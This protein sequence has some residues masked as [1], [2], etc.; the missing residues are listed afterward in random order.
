VKSY[1]EL[2]DSQLVE[3]IRSFEDVYKLR[4]ITD[5]SGGMDFDHSWATWHLLRMLQ[6][7]LIIESGVW[8]GHSTWLIEKAC[9]GSS[10]ICFEPNQ[11]RI[12][13]K[14]ENAEYFSHDFSQHDWKNYDTNSG[15]CFFDDHQNSYIRLM[16]MKWFGFSKVIFEDNPEPGDGDF[17]SISHILAGAGAPSLQMNYAYRGGLISQARRLVKE[18]ILKRIRHNQNLLVIPNESD[19]S[20][21]MRNATKIIQMPSVQAS[22]DSKNEVKSYRNNKLV[23]LE[24]TTK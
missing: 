18:A 19:K 23:Y 5:N 6:P 24:M 3:S 7:K 10:I 22:W 2:S 4:P 21:L 13:Y 9:P 15:L 16:Q 14:S 1:Q 17:Y 11:S 8:K 20:N 12:E